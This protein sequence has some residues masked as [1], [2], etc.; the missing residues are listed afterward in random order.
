VQPKRGG[1]LLRTEGALWFLP[2]SVVVCVVPLPPILRVAGAPDGVLGI[3][4]EAGEILPVV[5]IG[6][7]RTA[8]LVCT[9][10]G[11]PLGLVGCEIVRAGL[12]DADPQSPDCLLHEDERAK[13]FD[14][15]TIYARLQTTSWAAR[16]A[17]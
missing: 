1:I 11:E 7:D 8:L 14:L 4:H 15:S 5:E 2:A 13:V 9:Y 12:F 6:P 16:W 3:V 17:S 10:L